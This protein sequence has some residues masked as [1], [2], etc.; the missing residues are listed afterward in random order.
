MEQS[1][2]CFE[3]LSSTNQTN[4][5]LYSIEEIFDEAIMKTVPNEKGVAFMVQDKFSVFSIDP[6]KSNVRGMKF[7]TKGGNN[8]LQEGNIYY[9]YITSNETVESFQANIDIDLDIATYFPDDLLYYTNPNNDPSFRIV[10]K[11]YNNDILFQS[12][13]ITN[14]NQ[15]VEDKVISISI[16]GFD[17]NFQEKYL[18]ILFKVR[19]NHP[20]CYY[21]NYNSWVNAGIESSTNVSSFMFCK[22]NHLTPFTRITDVTK[23]VDV[24]SKTYK[25]LNVITQLGLSLSLLGVIGIFIS[26]YY[27]PEMRFSKSSKIMIQI[28][29]ALFLEI[30]LF[31]VAQSRA[32]NKREK[33]CITMGSLLQYVILVK[34]VWM[35]IIAV[36][37]WL[38]WYSPFKYGARRD[39]N[40]NKLEIWMIIVGWI[41]P[42]VPVFLSV[43]FVSKQDLD[44]CFPSGGAKIWGFLVPMYIMFTAIVIFFILLMLEFQKMVNTNVPGNNKQDV[45]Q[46]IIGNIR[47]LIFCMGIPWVFGSLHLIFSGGQLYGTIFSFLFCIF[48]PL[49]GFFMFLFL[50]VLNPRIQ[51]EVKKKINKK[52]KKTPRDEETT[53]STRL[54]SE[55]S[56]SISLSV[57]KTRWQNNP[58]YKGKQQIKDNTT[59]PL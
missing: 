3:K 53:A 32:V 54:T 29:I 40:E 49:Q 48:V 50:V 52:T 58:L 17:S 41:P 15:N 55:N 10:F 46:L 45:I 8:K 24:N 11:I 28:T 16:P 25:A 18:P 36:T 23:D 42:I 1:L 44:I 5:L 43:I 38:S 13:S 14:P 31:F 56:E 47:L 34:F 30:I 35:T 26:T 6:T 59:V 21:W 37:N 19:G 51:M 20:G 4:D 22:V 33:L 12:A 9:D 7:F 2:D 57:N 39:A 27:I